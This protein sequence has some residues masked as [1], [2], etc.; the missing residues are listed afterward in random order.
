MCFKIAVASGKGGTGKTTVSVSLFK[1]LSEKLENSVTLVDCDVEEPNTPFFFGD[2]K[3]LK[4]ENINQLIPSID[5]DRCTF[6]KKCVEYCEFNAISIIPSVKYAQIDASLCHSCGACSVACE[7]EAIT[8]HPSAIGKLYNYSTSFGSGLTVGKLKVGSAMQ[9]LVVGKTKASVTTS[10]KLILFDSPPGTSCPVVET[11]ADTDY[12]VLVTEPTPFGF[13]DIKLMIELVENLNIP[14]GVIINKAG[15]GNHQVHDFLIQ[16]NIELLGEI[17]FLKSY[18]T[19][20]SN[21]ELFENIPVEIER[22][23][24]IIANRLVQ[25]MKNS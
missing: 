12:V 18:A 17:P 23:F 4:K 1:F 22:T 13:H 14:F 25:I 11:I 15:M 2:A 16:R 20:Y 5:I 7:Y 24:Q 21:G 19:N 9:T 10:P 6:C 3:L 8:E